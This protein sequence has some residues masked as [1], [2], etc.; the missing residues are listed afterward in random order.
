MNEKTIFGAKQF[1]SYWKVFML[2]CIWNNLDNIDI[3]KISTMMRNER[4]NIL[5]ILWE[6]ERC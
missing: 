4:K 6:V 5:N 3:I 1:V 2:K